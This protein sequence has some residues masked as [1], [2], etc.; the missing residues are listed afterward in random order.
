MS[1][2]SR[3]EIVV[4]KDEKAIKKSRKRKI[5]G[6]I[7]ATVFVLI[8]VGMVVGSTVGA[9]KVAEGIW[10]ENIGIEAGVPF[11]D[12][13]S[14][15]KGVRKNNEK[16]IVTNAYGEDDLS[17]FYANIKNKMYL[18]E[19]YELDVMKILAKVVGGESQTPS[20]GSAQT[21]GDV[22]VSTRGTYGYDYVYV[23]TFADGREIE[24]NEPL[25]HEELGI[26]E[27]QDDIQ[28]PPQGSESTGNSALDDLL[29]EIEF[30]FSS[31]AD[32][33]GSKNIL[34][35]SDKQLAAFVNEV[36]SGIGEFIP[37]M[38]ELEDMIGCPLNEVLEVKQIIISGDIAHPES[39][40]LKITLNVK[41]KTLVSGI[42]DA[43]HLPSIVKSLMPDNIYASVTLYP[44]D[45]TRGIQAS[46][47]QMSEVNVDKIVRIADV[48]FKKTGAPTSLS[49]VLIDVN[50]KVVDVIENAQQ[51]IPLSFVTTG[52]VDLY[53]IETLMKTLKVDVSEQAFLTMIRDIKLPTAQSLGFDVYTKEIKENDTRT[54]ISEVTAKYGIDNSDNK[55]GEQN[56]IA[57]V[58]NFAQGED[59]I[60]KVNLKSIDYSGEYI[61]KNLKVG[62]SYQALSHML[63]SYMNE[64]QMLGTIKAEIVNMSSQKSGELEL[65]IEVDVAEMLGINGENTMSQLI[66]QLIPTS[67]FA[68]ATISLD[69]S[70]ST[71]VAINK[72]GVENSQNHLQTLTS[73]A[74]TFG[75]DVSALSYDSICNQLDSGIKQG[76]AKVKEQIGYEIEFYSDKAYL[77]SLYEVISGTPII[78]GDLQEGEHYFTPQEIRNILKYLYTFFYDE[79]S[80]NFTPTDNLDGFIAQLYD[81]YFIS[82]SYRAT[83]TEASHNNTLLNTMTLIGGDNFEMSKIRLD[84]IIDEETGKIVVGLKSRQNITDMS[85]VGDDEIERERILGEIIAKFNPVFTIE[86]TAHLISAQVNFSQVLT[87]MTDTQI[88]YANNYSAKGD[89]YL[90]LMF[91]GKGSIS[92]AN[93]TSLL[94][95]AIYIGVKIDL[96]SIEDGKR[97]DMKVFEMDVNNLVYDREKGE[98]DKDSIQD[99]Q[100]LLMLIDR[101]NGKASSAPTEPENPEEPNEPQPEPTPAPTNTTSLENIIANIE[102]KLNGK[103]DEEGTIVEEG[104]KDKIHNNVF[105]VTF[106]DNGGFRLDQTIYQIALNSIYAED[107]REEADSDKP[108]EI[109]FR[110]A[111]CKIN[112]M[113]D[114]TYING[115]SVSLTESNKKDAAV[116]VEEINEKYALKEGSKL[117]ANDLTAVLSD[118]GNKVER[119]ST[120]IDGNKLTSDYAAGTNYSDDLKKTLENLRPQIEEGELLNFLENSVT[121]TAQGYEDTQMLGLYIVGENEMSIV[122]KSKVKSSGKY[123]Q[124]LPVDIAMIVTTNISLIKT[125]DVCTSIVFNDLNEDEASAIDTVRNKIDPIENG[126]TSGATNIDEA[127]KSCSDSVKNSMKPLTDNMNLQFAVDG[128]TGK[129]IMDGIYEIAS[130]KVNALKADGALDVTAQGLKDTL[131]A[132]FEGLELQGYT[133][134]QKDITTTVNQAQEAD[135]NVLASTGGIKGVIGDGNISYK[136]DINTLKSSLGMSNSAGVDTLVL[137]QSALIGKGDASLDALRTSIGYA[138]ANS[139][140]TRISADKDY[141]LIT[142]SADMQSA[143]G[144]ELS[145]LPERMFITVFMD[146]DNADSNAQIVYNRLTD[147]QMNT[148]A[149]LMNA[150]AS[151]ASGF[152]D[153]GNIA[154]VKNQLTD[155][156]IIN[157]PLG[158]RDI[159]LGMLFAA[160]TNGGSDRVDQ[161]PIAN[162]TGKTSGVVVGTGALSFEIS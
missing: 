85:G 93:A 159:T 110:N 63:S 80:D 23:Y 41:L 119:Y 3:V 120:A 124:L 6:K 161:L 104:F 138:D 136:I 82:D 140:Q 121:I 111:V 134:A 24:S 78:N 88:V 128:G 84:D 133:G 7:L 77:P 13:F 59:I 105:T 65:D 98:S 9:Y 51:T 44:C 129:M 158:G 132:L 67:I 97:S 72:V 11:K 149:S 14:I 33:D 94:P 42:A 153:G 10:D 106:V 16:D 157:N 43:N 2:K 95:D 102:E 50:S 46:I 114:Q 32:Y 12:V 40:G 70:A 145:I 96:G 45:R 146:L 151:G 125:E 68:T 64:Q 126:A 76:L 60:N 20:D 122:Y 90:E 142:L 107:A 71:T 58:M 53:P 36:L 73:L 160:K 26:D 127:N 8:F 56:T 4:E 34:E 55:I 99:L 147:T 112:N 19:S 35:I 1:K 86:E 66:K 17:A 39:V 144:E 137:S 18:A 29:K 116:A 141:L 79:E 117:N 108:S 22:K 62:A 115:I 118:I 81:K 15:F 143:I 52:S 139:S 30:D 92:N 109:D 100:L 75:M 148:L 89:D 152:T 113:P 83:L 28:E 37:A 57:D 101:V 131:E 87:F 155:T 38:Q 91:K 154:K 21:L 135:F 31:L 130:E 27:G 47:N 74:T 54:F 61:E 123:A 103:K 25:G 5:T 162:V 48:I 150:N 69:G 156:V 49:Q